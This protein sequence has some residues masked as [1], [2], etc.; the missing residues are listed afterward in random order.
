MHA[1][2]RRARTSPVPE[3]DFEKTIRVQCRVADGDIDYVRDTAEWIRR[4]AAEVRRCNPTLAEPHV[5]R[6]V[7]DMSARGH[8]RLLAPET[9]AR[10]LALG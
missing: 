10:Q 5:M 4:C 6:E 3:L 2:S 9:V 1:G 7:L 8:F